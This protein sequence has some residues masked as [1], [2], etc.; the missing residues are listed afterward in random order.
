MGNI[1]VRILVQNILKLSTGCEEITVLTCVKECTLLLRYL[2]K[3]VV[4]RPCLVIP[5]CS[6]RGDSPIIQPRSCSWEMYVSAS[7]LCVT[8]AFSFFS[9]ISFSLPEQ[10]QNKTRQNRLSFHCSTITNCGLVESNPLFRLYTLYFQTWLLLLSHFTPL[11]V[12]ACRVFVIQS[13]QSPGR[14]PCKSL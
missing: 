8:S 10:Q 7:L 2:L 13:S 3:V 1:Y 11:H 14:G 12:T 6:S 9:L 4:A 5:L